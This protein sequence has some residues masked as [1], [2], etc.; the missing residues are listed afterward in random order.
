MGSRGVKNCL[1]VGT[2]QGQLQ[3]DDDRHEVDW[4]DHLLRANHKFF[5]IS[6]VFV[7][8][9]SMRFIVYFWSLTRASVFVISIVSVNLPP[10][11]VFYPHICLCPC[12]FSSSL[13][14]FLSLSTHPHRVSLVPHLSQ[15]VS[16]DRRL[17]LLPEASPKGSHLQHNDHI[18]LEVI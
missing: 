2:L 11:C 5:S 3:D 12:L 14:L 18:I 17:Q 9:H 1:H 4:A 6:R 10:S 7:T 13:S 8:S 16:L 15:D